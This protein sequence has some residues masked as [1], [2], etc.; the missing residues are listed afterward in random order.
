MMSQANSV[1]RDV[2]NR[3]I[4]IMALLIFIGIAIIVFINISGPQQVQPVNKQDSSGIID[5]TLPPKIV[6][7]LLD[8]GVEHIIL[9]GP[10]GKEMGTYALLHD[11]TAAACISAP[12]LGLTPNT[13]KNGG[14]RTHLGI[15]GI[16]EATAGH[17][18]PDNCNCS[19]PHCKQVGSKCCQ[20]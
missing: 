10:E 8:N 9:F 19:G 6:K 20:C 4:K 1:D 12:Q 2:R 3:R 17:I 14:A 16:N 18:C 11:L 15:I 13:D 7:S 5:F